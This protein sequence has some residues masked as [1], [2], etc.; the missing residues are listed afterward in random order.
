[1]PASAL[2]IGASAA[3]IASLNLCADEYA[4]LLA[5]PGEL[6]SVT[7]LSHDP[8]ESPLA[9]RARTIP[10]NRGALED[11][12]AQRPDVILTMGGAGRSTR[13]L[14]GRMGIRS[15]DLPSPVDVAGVERNLRTVAAALGDPGRAAPLLERIARLKAAR[16]G[17]QGDALYLSGGGVSV[18]SWSPAVEWLA[19][20]GLRQR[21]LPSGKVTLEQLLINPPAIIIRS[22]YRAGQMSLGQRWF[23]HPIVRRSA[24]R[25][26]A[27]DGR[28]WTCA[29]PLM[30]R[31][32]ERLKAA[33]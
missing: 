19:L 27:S 17:S 29:G 22:D 21:S 25:T 23:D 12:V 20:A 30:I 2:L 7:R 3:R 15:I 4:L 11:V 10:A 28:A 26:L 18:G 16:P 13:L 6:V 8:L 33:R 31:E 24:A 9:P 32:I 14:A 5:R 1:M